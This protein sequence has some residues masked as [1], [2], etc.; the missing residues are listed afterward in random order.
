MNHHH[1]TQGVLLLEVTLPIPNSPIFD[2][3]FHRP[4]V[5]NEAVLKR[6]NDPKTLEGSA[7]TG[8]SNYWRSSSLTQ[9]PTITPMP[10]ATGILKVD[11]YSGTTYVINTSGARHSALLSAASRG[12]DIAA[13]A[14]RRR[15]RVSASSAEIPLSATIERS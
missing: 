5:T 2:R 7:R 10:D 11:H 14:G 1:S 8:S 12:W 3:C 13:S 4:I 9:W 6:K 15:G